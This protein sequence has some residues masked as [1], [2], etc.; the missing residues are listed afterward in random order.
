MDKRCGSRMMASD[1]THINYHKYFLRNGTSHWATDPKLHAWMLT[2]PRYAQYFV[3]HP[4]K[5]TSKP[6]MTFGAFEQRILPNAYRTQTAQYQR[7]KEE[8]SLTDY[9]EGVP[10]PSVLEAPDVIEQFA[11][12]TASVPITDPQREQTINE[13][14][15]QYLRTR[16]TRPKQRDDQG[17]LIEEGRATG[18]A[19]ES[20]R[21]QQREKEILLNMFRG[22]RR[23]MSKANLK[24]LAE[25]LGIMLPLRVTA[26]EIISLIEESFEESGAADQSRRDI[27]GRR[28]EL[29]QRDDFWDDF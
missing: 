19:E 20:R 11:R 22:Q 8:G 5:V 17:R 26:P 10:S 3:Q 27:F 24:R 7:A 15:K 28:R 4:L 16:L 9:V 6:Q 18:I 23:G 21:S 2:Q 13:L 29:P 1:P 14:K 25:L 12:I